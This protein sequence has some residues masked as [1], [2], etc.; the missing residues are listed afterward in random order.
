[1]ASY[2]GAV[3]HDASTKNASARAKYRL[4][5]VNRIVFI[6]PLRDTWG[7]QWGNSNVILRRRVCLLAEAILSLRAVG[8]RPADS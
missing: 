6:N 5:C 7:R 4:K 3:A 2:W 8:S 1:V